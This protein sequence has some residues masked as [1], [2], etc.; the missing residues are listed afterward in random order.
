VAA[1]PRARQGHAAINKQHT[2]QPHRHQRLGSLSSS[3]SPSMQSTAALVVPVAMAVA[4]VVVTLAVAVA[5]VCWG[6]CCKGGKSQS[7]QLLARQG[8]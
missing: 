8:S 7:H 1:D 6:C 2:Y 4:L 5:V 3:Q